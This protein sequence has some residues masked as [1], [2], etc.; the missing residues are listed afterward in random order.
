MKRRLFK[1]HKAPKE[2]EWERNQEHRWGCRF[3]PKEKLPS[4]SATR[5]GVGRMSKETPKFGM[6]ERGR[7]R[8]GLEFEGL[9]IE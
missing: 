6:G 2:A 1:R 3:V 7:W 4:P 8:S 9:P 5:V